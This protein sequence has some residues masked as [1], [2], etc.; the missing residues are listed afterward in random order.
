MVNIDKIKALA[1]EQGIKI[2]YLTQQL[3]ISHTFFA[4]AAKG[5][6]KISDERLS[7]I[8]DILN[9]TP[10]YLR[11]ETD[12]KEKPLQKQEL[13]EQDKE[14][15]KLLHSVSDEDRRTALAM[16]DAFLQARSEERK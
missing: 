4:D 14:F 9:T 3:G 7:I 13:N 15:I 12:I 1:K 11:D 10:E 16:L 2:K 5:K 6:V 8:A